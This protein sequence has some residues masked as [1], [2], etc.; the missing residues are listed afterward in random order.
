MLMGYRPVVFESSDSFASA[1]LLP[2]Y[3]WVYFYSAVQFAAEM[4]YPQLCSPRWMEYSLHWV[5]GYFLQTGQGFTRDDR[6][7]ERGL[8]LE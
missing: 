7:S 6:N 8:G 4:V 2:L 3:C 1:P 5:R